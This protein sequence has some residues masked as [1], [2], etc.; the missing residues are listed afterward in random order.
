MVVI[1]NVKHGIRQPAEALRMAV[2]VFLILVPM[3][4][5]NI[6]W[7]LQVAGAKA[8]QGAKQRFI[9]GIINVLVIIYKRIIVNNL[10]S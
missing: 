7:R 2:L 3:A 8:Q 6:T 9:S 1:T 5:S 4:I 10:I